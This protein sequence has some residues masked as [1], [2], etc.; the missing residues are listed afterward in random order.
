MTPRRTTRNP[1]R[2]GNETRPG[3][4]IVG[5][6][7]THWASPTN[8]EGQET[9]AEQGRT[10][11]LGDL[12][13]R[14]VIDDYLI[15]RIVAEVEK[16]VLRVHVHIDLRQL[17]NEVAEELLGT[18]TDDPIR[19]IAGVNGE[20]GSQ[21]E[22]DGN[23]E[24]DIQI[25]SR[26]GCDGVVG[27]LE[28]EFDPD[29]CSGPE[30]TGCGGR[31]AEVEIG[32]RNGRCESVGEIFP[33]WSEAASDTPAGKPPRCVR[34]IESAYERGRSTHAEAGDQLVGRTGKTLVG[35]AV[36]IGV[37][38][39]TGAG[40]FVSLEGDDRGTR[41]RVKAGEKDARGKNFWGHGGW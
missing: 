21:V 6:C 32:E 1:A 35:V 41:D 15:P 3:L 37:T 38:G 10:G 23:C 9:Q 14:W 28:F 20:G 16:A 36:G 40:I 30:L 5:L 29:P 27:H 11:G 22:V 17:R 34:E 31:D 26:V 19:K 18:P 12:L 8:A 33:K 24:S 39:I 13:E 4:D 25:S 7:N 2:S